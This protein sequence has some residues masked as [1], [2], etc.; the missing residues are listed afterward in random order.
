[1]FRLVSSSL[2]PLPVSLLP[3]LPPPSML[4]SKPR[5]RY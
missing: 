4:V 3:A 1:V 2:P 5:S